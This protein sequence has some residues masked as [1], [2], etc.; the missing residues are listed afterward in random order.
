TKANSIDDTIVEGITQSVDIAERDFRAMVIYNE[1]D[2]F[3]VGANLFAVVMAAQQ[4]AWDQLRSTIS[5]L[6]GGLQ[7]MKYSTIPVVAAPLWVWVFCRAARA[8]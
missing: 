6:Q 2:H 7:R 1:G 4:K 3:C 5:G 8:T